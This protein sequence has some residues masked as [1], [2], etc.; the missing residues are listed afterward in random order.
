MHAAID[1]EEDA[2]CQR[3]LGAAL[4]FLLGY[5]EAIRACQAMS[6]HAAL[7]HLVSEKM[8]QT[9]GAPK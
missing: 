1:A 8:V 5:E 3:Q 6:W 9:M 7:L 2:K 4:A